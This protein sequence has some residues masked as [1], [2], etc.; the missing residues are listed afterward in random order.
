VLDARRCISYLTIEKRGAIPAELYEGI[1]SHLF[2]CDLCQE[3]CPWN[4]RRARPLA[5]EPRFAPR[6]EWLAPSVRELLALD[7]EALHARLRGSALKRAKLEGLRRNALVAAGNSGDPGLLRFVEP[8]LDS[9]DAGIADAAR[10]ARDRL[11]ARASPP[12][13]EDRPT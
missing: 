7:D 9:R 12:A 8:W 2:G 6:A 11:T 1:G 4:Q 5:D 13:A 3:V 10:Y